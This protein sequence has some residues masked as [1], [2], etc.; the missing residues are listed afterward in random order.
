[1]SSNWLHFCSSAD[2][3]KFFWEKWNWKRRPE[4][5]EESEVNG[6]R[7]NEAVIESEIESVVAYRDF[8]I[9]H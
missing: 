4:T 9:P 5:R 1:M 8:R 2:R 7:E 6:E 3:P